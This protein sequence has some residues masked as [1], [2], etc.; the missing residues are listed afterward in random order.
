MPIQFAR[1]LWLLPLALLTAGCAAATNL[2]TIGNLLGGVLLPGPGAQPA[3]VAAEIDRIDT[4]RRIIFVRTEDDETSGV[5]YDANTTAHYR[6]QLYPIA[7]LE[8]ADLFV[9]H[10]QLD[11]HGNRYASRIDVT[12]TAQERPGAGDIQRFGGRITAID[13]DRGTFVLLTNDGSVTVS[14]PADAPQATDNFFR[15]LKV[16][17]EVRLEGRVTGEGRVEIHRFL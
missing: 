1:R 5:L 10:V 6:G 7:A 12:R 15:T 13:H 3:Q 9:L 4:Q 2:A 8:R 14:L 16:D 17:D 11:A